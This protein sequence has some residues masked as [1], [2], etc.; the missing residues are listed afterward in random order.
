M[1]QQVDRL[2]EVRNLSVGVRRYSVEIKMFHL[3]FWLSLL[4][5]RFHQG[6]EKDIQGYL[7]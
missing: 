6:V 2:A 5:Q 3:L 7:C 1:V 4:R